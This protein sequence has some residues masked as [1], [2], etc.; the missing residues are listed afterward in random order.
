MCYL[1]HCDR[2]PLEDQVTIVKNARKEAKRRWRFGSMLSADYDQPKEVASVSPKSTGAAG[3]GRFLQLT[4][5][6]FDIQYKVNSATLESQDSHH[7]R[8]H[9][10]VQMRIAMCL[11]A[12]GLG[13]FP[14]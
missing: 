13:R 11:F 7:F 9:R 4:D 12:A 2:R 3:I 10:R 14:H 6:H 1:T 5:M 8:Q